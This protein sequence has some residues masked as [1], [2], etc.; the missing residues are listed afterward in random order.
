MRHPPRATCKRLAA[1]K[2]SLADARFGHRRP[3][4][5]RAQRRTGFFKITFVGGQQ[6][7][8]PQRQRTARQSCHRTQAGI[9]KITRLARYATLSNREMP[10][11]TAGI[12]R[13]D[14]GAL[15]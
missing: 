2:C 1:R 6:G 15:E 5:T 14:P 13:G 10:E 12:A 4:G 3:A 8:N 7:F 9:A 11:H